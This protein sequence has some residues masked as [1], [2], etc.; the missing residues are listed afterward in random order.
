[1]PKRVQRAKRILPA[2]RPKKGR[3]GVS[4]AL[5][6]A[7]SRAIADGAIEVGEM[8]PPERELAA[9][10]RVGRVTVRTALADLVRRGLLECCPG[11]G[12]RVVRSKVVSQDTSPV[13]IIYRDISQLGRSASKS[14]GAIEA[15]LAEKNRA[16]LIGS[17]GFTSEGENACIRRFRNAGAGALIVVPAQTGSRST[18][19]E[20]WIRSRKPIVLEG[21]PGNWLLPDDLA[22]RCDQIDVDNRDGVEQVLSHLVGLGHRRIAL[23]SGSAAEGSE[24]VE[25][26]LSYVRDRGL[27]RRDEWV[28]T[29]LAATTKDPMQAGRIAHGRLAT[30]PEPPTAVFCTDDDLAT[31]Y[32]EAA[33]SIGQACPRDISVAGFGNEARHAPGNGTALTTVDFSRESLA[34]EITRLLEAQA[35]N[36]RR[37]PEKVRLPMQ[38]IVR[39]SCGVPRMPVAVSETASE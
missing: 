33:R 34:R 37:D 17:S 21:H 36:G 38:L 30:V 24:R 23:L 35:S 18:E 2:G 25:A 4:E 28:V 31:G 27:E 3:G 39:E 13:G 16:L 14:V 8:M 29:C 9:R 1:M 10:H 22:E 19:L 26:F 12:Y 15:A 7:L 20:A 6:A 11:L 32:L 5:A